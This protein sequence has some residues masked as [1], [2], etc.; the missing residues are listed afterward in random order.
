LNTQT[1]IYHSISE[2]AKMMRLEAYVLRFWEKEFR[3]L[4]PKKNRAGNRIYQQKDIDILMQI[5]LLLYDKGFTIEGARNYLKDNG[6]S[7]NS[8][9]KS[10]MAV[11][12]LK[13]V[14]TDIDDMLKLFP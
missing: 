1:K 5:K 14:R 7:N 11:K 12:L 13:E 4:R 2:V 3:Q 6:K 9:L 10:E 8:K